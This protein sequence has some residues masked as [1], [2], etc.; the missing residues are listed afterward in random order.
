MQT[1]FM[2][3]HNRIADDLQKKH[4]AWSDEKIFQ[5]ARK[6]VIGEIQAVTY[7]EFLPA[8]LG[9]NALPRYEG[10]N[11]AVN[12][13]ISNEFST[14]AFRLGHSMLGDD[15]ELVDNDG[16]ELPG[17]SL[18]DGF[19]NPDV[20]KQNGIGTLLKGSATGNAEEVDT[21][22]VDSVRN[23][24]FGPPGAGGL[25]LISLNIQRGRDHGLADYNSSR[26]AFGLPKVKSFAQITSDPEM[27]K[28]LKDLYG[29]VDNIDMWVGA[30]AED[31]V[32]GSSTGPLIRS[33]LVD[34][35]TRLRD[36]DRFF[37]K[38]QFHGSE[39]KAIDST[40]LS[41]IIQR[42]TEISNIQDNVFIFHESPEK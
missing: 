23:F 14:A 11:P 27:Q 7:N 28:K 13:G 10:Y 42:N 32:K 22:A 5:N 37:Y 36:G 33:V 12:P 30:L 24:L 19:F 6:Q 17:M 8:L 3:E 21:I 20:V 16:K 25:D 34:Q 38:N 26:A 35:F 2:R 18:A 15:I 41:D 40:K 39:L 29:S 4:P 31:H 1:L 9:K